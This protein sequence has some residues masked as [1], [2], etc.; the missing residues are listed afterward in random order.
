MEEWLTKAVR[1]NNSFF[2]SPSTHWID[3]H[4]ESFMGNCGE[5]LRIACTLGDFGSTAMRIALDEWKT[6]VARALMRAGVSMPGKDGNGWAPIHTAARGMKFCESVH[7]CVGVVELLVDAAVDVNC[8][9]GD[10]DTPMHLALSSGGAKIIRTLIRGGARADVM[11]KRG[12]TPLFC[13]VDKRL[14][15][16]VR[17]LCSASG[18]QASFKMKYLGKAPLHTAAHCGYADIVKLLIEKQSGLDMTNPKG[19]TPLHLAASRGHVEVIDMLV[20]AGA[21]THVKNKYGRNPHD[22]AKTEACKKALM[23]TK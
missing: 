19:S 18:A 22:I 13:A 1:T 3:C 7:Y 2:S 21:R 14:V 4:S 9:N 11:D 5:A 15:E 20:R 12:R 17:A 6:E 10:G 8:T 16:V 23:K